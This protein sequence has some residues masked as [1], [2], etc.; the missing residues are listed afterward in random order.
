MTWK[1]FATDGTAYRSL[2]WCKC[3]G[4]DD[5]CHEY[6]LGQDNCI[7]CGLRWDYMGP[8]TIEE[9]EEDEFTF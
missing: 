5:G 3:P 1:Q 8:E 7:Y 6:P 4:S 2:S 9:T